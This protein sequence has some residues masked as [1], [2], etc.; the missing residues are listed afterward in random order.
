MSEDETTILAPRFI[1]GDQ[2]SMVLGVLG[3]M[4]SGSMTYILQAKIVPVTWDKV[5]M[6]KEATPTL[7]EENR[8]IHTIFLIHDPIISIIWYSFLCFITFF[9]IYQYK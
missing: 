9:F 5:E 2:T 6:V 3:E 4:H 8:Y 1:R 7:N